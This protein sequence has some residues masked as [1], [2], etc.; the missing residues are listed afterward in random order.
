MAWG[1]LVSSFAL[2]GCVAHQEATL[3]EAITAPGG[4]LVARLSLEA[5]TRAPTITVT[6]LDRVLVRAMGLGI[7]F[8]DA[9]PFGSGLRIVDRRLRRHRGSYEHALGKRRTLM[10][11][12]R[13]VVWTLRE[14]EAP[15]RVAEL[16]VRV[17]D[18][19]VSYRWRIISW[20]GETGALVAGELADHRVFGNPRSFPLYREHFQTS[21]EGPYAR[22]RL[23]ELQSDRLIDLPLLFAHDDGTCLAFTEACVRGYPHG[24]FQRVAGK[25]ARLVP[26]LSRRLDDERVAA[27]VTVPFRTPWRTWLIGASIAR[28]LE[29]DV[30]LHLCEPPA[31]TDWSW[32]RAGKQT[33]HWWNGTVLGHDDEGGV[34][35]QTMRGYIDFC[36]RA[37]IRY[38]A[39]NGQR[40][41]WY[42]Q[43]RGSVLPS[44]DADVLVARP[45]LRWEALRSYAENCGVKLRLWAHWRAL[46]PKLDAAFALY[47]RWG[48]SG[49][50][51]DFLDRDDQE[52][53]QFC[54]RVL[55]VAA[56]HKLTIQ[57]HG[58]FKPTG[59]R[60]TFP[61]LMNHEGSA[62]LEVLKWSTGC[63]PDHDLIVPF[64]RGLAGPV[65]YHLGGFRAARRRELKPRNVRPRVFGTRARALAW[66]VVLENPLPMVSDYPEAYS[67]QAGFDLLTG[68]PTTWDESR[69]LSAAI[70]EHIAWARRKGKCWYLGAVTD[71][72][73]RQIDV[74]LAFLGPGKH[75]MRLLTDSTDETS[76]PNSVVESRR[77]VSASEVL[78]LRLAPG[79]GALAV[80]N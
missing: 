26:R 20:P 3:T 63:D 17:H 30:L 7:T 19:G 41:P 62:N 36:A 52:M 67:G 1:C 70:G 34:D 78:Q 13:E 28:L 15:A 58:S 68:I 23:A 25:P 32:V 12:H 76:D 73:S 53:V 24:Y 75:R 45:E 31:A 21:H 18:D 44:P 37:G 11:D 77:Q 66:Y 65:D 33:W 47:Q 5:E 4:H 6:L 43:S 40:Q 51:V 54:E 61:H 49:L 48:I 71:W 64:T 50:M 2:L 74:P 55:E 9:P 39:V 10:D 69:V 35:F 46:R 27:K 60:R 16:H 80:F 8:V 72:T 57:F 79:G 56:R 42:V 14:D 59:L 22:T 38:H 29:S